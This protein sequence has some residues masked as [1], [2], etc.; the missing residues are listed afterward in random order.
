MQRHQLTLLLT[1]P[2]FNIDVVEDTTVCIFQESTLIFLDT[3][4]LWTRIDQL[5]IL[6]EGLG[7]LTP[8]VDL[9]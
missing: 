3:W 8:Q 7:L 6:A 9:V 4:P 1:A 2:L 5:K